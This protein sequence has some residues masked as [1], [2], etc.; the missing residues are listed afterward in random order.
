[1]I[2][3]VILL[4]SLAATIGLIMVFIGI[5]YRRG[6]LVLGLG[7]AGIASLALTLLVVQIFRERVHHL[8]YNDAALL[9]ILTLL[10]GLVLLAL[11]E[12]RKPPP[13]IVVGLHAAM[14][15]FALLLLVAGYLHR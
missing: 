15:L 2:L 12:S 4:F 13:M 3:V 8:L 11:R 7:H 5:R 1:M 6:S 10:G 9:F 14:A